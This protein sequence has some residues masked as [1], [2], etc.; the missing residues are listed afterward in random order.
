MKVLEQVPRLHML[1]EMA[2]IQPLEKKNRGTEPE[3]S[4]LDVSEDAEH[5]LLCFSGK[6]AGKKRRFLCGLKNTSL[7][8]SL[9]ATAIL[10]WAYR[11]ELRND[12]SFRVNQ[13]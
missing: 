1:L 9:R 4:N 7:K 11:A 8:L 2:S 10:Y 12:P 5:S 6:L 13:R 3:L